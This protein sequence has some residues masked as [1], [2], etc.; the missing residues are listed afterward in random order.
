M[1]TLFGKKKISIDHLVNYTIH[2]VFDIVDNHFED[3]KELLKIS[4]EFTQQPPV[5]TMQADMLY[6][7]LFAAHME[8]MEQ[9]L[10][11]PYHQT[12]PKNLC[13]KLGEI[14]N[15]P[16][17]QME[18]MLKDELG[19]I[20]QIN[21]PSKNLLYGLTKAFFNRYQLY[22]FQEEY[23]KNLQVPNP[24]LLKRLDEIFA[25]FLINY[26]ELLNNYRI[27]Q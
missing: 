27:K 1:I 23:F 13:E 21:L 15:V 9:N 16:A 26:E 2:F 7:I 8:L 18:K 5:E 14:Y 11:A 10:P 24:I 22:K 3:I 20:K 4:P 12:G 19:F 17:E 6:L 25:L